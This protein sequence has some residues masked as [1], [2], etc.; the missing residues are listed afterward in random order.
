MPTADI[1]G[2]WP[3]ILQNWIT[4]R[5]SYIP[6]LVLLCLFAMTANVCG[7]DGVYICK[8]KDAYSYHVKQGCAALKRCNYGVQFVSC[9]DAVARGR[10]ACRKCSYDCNQVRGS[11]EYISEGTDVT[12]ADLGG[13]HDN[14]VDV[15]LLL[16][17][18]NAT[19]L[20]LDSFVLSK[21]I[22]SLRLVT[23]A[24]QS[25]VSMCDHRLKIMQEEMQELRYKDATDDSIIIKRLASLEAKP[26]AGQAASKRYR[27]SLTLDG[28]LLVSPRLANNTISHYATEIAI[29]IGLSSQYN[30]GSFYQS[31][32][33]TEFETGVVSEVVSLFDMSTGSNAYWVI[34]AGGYLE[35]RDRLMISITSPVIR[36][37]VSQG[38]MDGMSGKLIY[39]ILTRPI[40]L[41]LFVGA[42]HEPHNDNIIPQIGLR[43]AIRG[44]RGS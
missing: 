12:D 36:S 34:R 40:V 8:S 31:S 10:S 23:K 11:D 28:A 22:D 9:A 18:T 35:L 42:T 4:S 19:G 20:L 14:P 26:A 41:G 16:K 30:H 17:P 15:N 24:L 21:Q 44:L 32:N 1:N 5:S 38:V 13:Y 7:Q 27:Y 39:S 2:K 3:M 43:V 29:Q 6:V 25:A 37:S 33:T